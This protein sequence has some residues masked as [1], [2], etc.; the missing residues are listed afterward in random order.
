[1]KEINGD[2]IQL[3]KKGQFDVIVHGCNC[4]NT[5]GAGIALQMKSAFPQAWDVD[6]NTIKGY[7]R[8][9]GKYT[10]ATIDIQLESSIHQLTIV[11]AYTQL[12]PGV[13]LLQQNY[14]AIADCFVR[15]KREF[16]GKCFGIPLI[17]CGLAGGEW[18][19][20]GEIIDNIMDDED[21]TLVRY[22][23]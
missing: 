6:R 5:W 20:V 22:I 17:G 16:S 19:I 9:L 15:I 14:K 7:E 3:A 13:N 12:R 1:M 8:K 10:K 4:Y 2:L 23:K 18:D 21:I 11:N